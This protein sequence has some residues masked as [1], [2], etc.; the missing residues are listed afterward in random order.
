MHKQLAALTAVCA[1]GN[2]IT[3]DISSNPLPVTEIAFRFSAGSKGGHMSH[4]VWA[5]PFKLNVPT[6]GMAV[7]S[8]E[9]NKRGSEQTSA[10]LSEDLLRVDF[11]L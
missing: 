4:T 10:M 2:T 8:T 1:F 11:S 6:I 5:T 3:L 7:I 9:S